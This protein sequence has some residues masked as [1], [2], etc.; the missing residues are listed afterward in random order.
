MKLRPWMIGF[1]ALVFAGAV[2]AADETSGSATTQQQKNRAT[3]GGWNVAAIYN[4]GWSAEQMIGSDVR[5]ENGEEIGQVKDIVVGADGKISKVVVEVGGWLEMG[6]QHIGVPWK[7]VEIGRDM[8]WVQVPL[9]EVESG[10]YSLF[11]RVPQGENVSAARNSWRVNE[12]IGDY[13]SIGDVARYGIVADV[14]FDDQGQ[15]NAVVVNR[16]AGAWGRAGWYGYPYAGYFPDTYAYSLSSGSEKIGD[17][18][19]FDY[20]ELAETS[21]YARDDRAL[22]QTRGMQAQQTE[23]GSQRRDAIAVQ[24]GDRE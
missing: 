1:S 18:Q 14:I 3:S 13:A 20:G 11:G 17:A 5:G 23:N 10:T 2:S 4:S 6:D 8:Q 19:P 9:R 15:A 16:T 12:L 24:Q 22:P 7:D 21:P